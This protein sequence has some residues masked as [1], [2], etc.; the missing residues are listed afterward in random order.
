MRKSRRAFWGL[1]L[2]VAGVVLLAEG[3][4]SEIPSFDQVWPAILVAGGVAALISYVLGDR[5]NPAQIS[6]G[7]AATLAGVLFFF[8][9]VGPL[10]YE[11]LGAW[12]PAFVLIGSVAWLGQW[13][14]TGF[15]D[16]G[17]LFLGLVALVF[18]AAGVAVALELLGPQTRESLPRLWPVLL[19]VG[20]V[21]VFLRAAL[22][23]RS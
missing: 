21:M 11:D 9:T 8:I 10:E 23:R 22:G 4:G 20:G 1:V 16:W 17:A 13:A 15:R 6:L 18:G 7:L 12:W 14:A 2:I 19:I 3:L 5:R